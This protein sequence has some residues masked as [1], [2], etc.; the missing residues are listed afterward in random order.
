MKSKSFLEKKIVVGILIAVFVISILAVGWI[1][2]GLLQ[3]GVS[4]TSTIL[5]SSTATVITPDPI[6][7]IQITPADTPTLTVTPS[8]TNSVTPTTEPVMSIGGFIL[9]MRD[10]AYYHLY[11]YNP[12]SHPFVRLTNG[13]WDDISP[14][15]N[16]DGTKLVF[17]SNRNGYWDLYMLD[18]VTGETFQLTV[19]KEFE[20]SPA[21]SP[22]GLWIVFDRYSNSNSNLYILDM[23][24]RTS[25]PTQ[26]LHDNAEDSQPSWSPRGRQIAFASIQNN[27]STVWIANLDNISNL[28]TNVETP[29]SI[30]QLNPAWSSSGQYLSWS[31]VVDGNRFIFVKDMDT[32]A[33]PA[34]NI[35]EGSTCTWDKN[36]Q[37]LYVLVESP[38]QT[39]LVGYNL[40]DSTL[41]MPLI[42]LPTSV[43]GFTQVINDG[44]EWWN[45]FLSSSTASTPRNS[46]IPSIDA[47]ISG[48]QNVVPLDG[49]KVPYAFLLPS[50]KT[51]FLAL[52][53]DTSSRVGWDFLNTLD[54]AFLPLT[55]PP[56]P[57]NADAWF[58]TGRAIALNSQ[59]LTAGW[60]A[61]VREDFSGQVYWHI[62]IKCYK[63][64]GSMGAPLQQLVW[65]LSARSSGSKQAYEDGGKY[66]SPPSGFW[67]DFTDLAQNEGWE[68]LPAL[69]NWRSYYPA[70]RYN[71]FT[72]T[73]GL[74]ISTS[75]SQMYP[76]E[77]LMTYTPVPT[78]DLIL[79]TPSVHP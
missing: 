44:Q 1:A 5:P 3:R 45:S 17:S 9:S 55:I 50:V 51:S 18:L 35:G 6:A 16:P 41:A 30:D 10:G 75:L 19:T 60:M 43:R 14:A 21:W 66:A 79:S 47:S 39:D 69:S 26:L 29:T 64:D 58:F 37:V 4:Q 63:Q 57:G 8:D 32:P 33:D 49:I 25:P 76:P 20:G 65:D 27:E 78:S 77:A 38:N 52:K 36:R 56:D 54:N 24:N 23:N 28:F 73:G 11:Y 62:F 67:E 53:S 48:R 42:H 2:L 74:D 7:S 40:A 61:L 72:M 68:R 70:I 15:V 46:I 34:R 12:D 31:G 13:N 59:A 22:D 71:Q